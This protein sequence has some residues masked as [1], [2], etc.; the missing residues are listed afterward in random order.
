M[1][2][3]LKCIYEYLYAIDSC[4]GPSSCLLISSMVSTVAL[5]GAAVA[6]YVVWCCR[7]G[8]S[9]GAESSGLGD[10]WRMEWSLNEGVTFMKGI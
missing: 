7:S 4:I 9:V 10:R 5:A 1:G 3:S 2:A 8:W 6:S